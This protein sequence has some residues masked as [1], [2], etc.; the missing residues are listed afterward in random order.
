MARRWHVGTLCI[1]AILAGI[2]LVANAVNYD[3]YS[4]RDVLFPR[5]LPPA[6]IGGAC[7][8]SGHCKPGLCCQQ[9]RNGGT[10]CQP[11]ARLHQPCTEGQV[12]GGAYPFY[13][14]CLQGTCSLRQGDNGVCVAGQ[15]LPG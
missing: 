8:N 11:M 7:R 15:G 3:D 9:G 13:C 14:P 10:S 6:G 1:F 12:K 5:G 4:Q 2:A